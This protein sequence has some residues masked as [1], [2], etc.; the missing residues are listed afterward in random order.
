M[1]GYTI[2]VIDDEKAQLETL[3]GF[4]KKKG[5]QVEKADSGTAGLE[6]VKSKAIDLIL[7][8]FKMPDKDGVTVLHEAKQIN[9]EI[10]VIV[11]TAYGSIESATEA[12]K[13]GAI[14]YLTKPIDLDQLELIVAK[15][16]ERKQ[17]VSENRELK[18]QL[19][20]KFK[21][22]EI[23]SS[24]REMEEVL[25]TAAR[26]APSQATVLIRGESG[27]GK[28]LVA[29]AIHYASQRKDRSFI[30]VN[31]AALAENIL[32]SELFGHEKGA[33]TGAD[34]Q[35]K[36]RFELA[37][38][39]TLFL[40][41]IGEI[42]LS[43]QV[44]LL[45]V[46]QEKSFE[47]VG[48]SET[49][50]VDV[51]LIA[52][53]NRDLEDMLT[54]KTFRDDLYYRLNVVSVSVPPL[55]EHKTDIHPL[56]SH[57]LRKFAD[58]NKKQVSGISREAMDLLLKYSYPGNIRELENI[59]EQ[60]VVLARG[61]IITSRDLPM[62]V[63]GLKSEKKESLDLTPGS[64]EERV[65]TFET[66]L[67]QEALAATN[68]VQTKAAEILGMTERHLRYKLKKYGMK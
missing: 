62:N 19:E 39:G 53:T 15:A 56:T 27:T 37:H 63:Q 13:A 2:L 12:M 35:R 6:L 1:L 58:L 68:G 25:N 7:T 67:I 18:K 54:E 64:F 41:E 59:I 24:S 36:G 52:A 14:D 9:P 29:K 43:T 55:R 8:D 28:E 17:L 42:P 23:I 47:R 51:R 46:L 49:I 50:K 38:D 5:Y 20:E 11:M 21:F 61:E 22:A 16:L 4:L 33:F 45:R 32:E 31:C 40:D 48:S 3:A 34:R 65:A 57:F 30:A 10:D 60:A 26:V 66:K 44:K